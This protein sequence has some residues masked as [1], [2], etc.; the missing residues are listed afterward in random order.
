[1]QLYK[2]YVAFMYTYSSRYTWW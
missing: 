2:L 1:L